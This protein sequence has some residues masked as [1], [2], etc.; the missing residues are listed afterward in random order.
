MNH[1]I[2]KIGSK[3]MKYEVDLLKLCGVLGYESI[4]KMYD[5]HMI[6]REQLEHVSYMWKQANKETY[7]IIIKSFN[8]GN[9]EFEEIVY[10]NPNDMLDIVYQHTQGGEITIEQVLLSKDMFIAEKMLSALN[11]VLNLRLSFNMKC[12]DI[13]CAILVLKN[14]A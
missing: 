9:N 4:Q 2:Y 14:L 11:T 12:K 8:D 5:S 6:N 7:K 13:K 1:L 3:K 10:I